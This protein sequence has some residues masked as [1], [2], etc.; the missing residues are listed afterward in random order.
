MAGSAGADRVSRERIIAAFLAR[1]GYG[2][3]RTEPLAQDASFRRYLRLSGGPRA[4]VVMDARPPEDIRPFVRIAGHL[5]GIGMSVPEI[6]A[7]DEM[8]GLLL[9][10]D[11]GDEQVS[12][13][14][15]AVDTL[16]AMQRAAPPAGLPAWDAA[17][18]AATALATLFDWWWPAMF[19]AGAPN[20]A[21]RDFAGALEAMLASVAGP[22]CFVHRDYFAG[23]LL[24]LPQRNGIRRIGVLDFQ[25]AANGHPAYDLAA[26]LQDA[27]RDIPPVVA[28][29]CMAQYLAARP[30]LDPTQFRAAYAACAVQR[31]LRLVGQWVR[32]ALRDRRPSYLAHGPR[33]WR[34][35]EHAVREP[36]AAP[37]AAAL[38]RW[39]PPDRRRNPP[40][41]AA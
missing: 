19:C 5:A 25:D 39:I 17:T 4:A 29:H 35:L 27:R 36:V 13:Y 41:I 14:S 28:E 16:I 34:L 18:M 11:F 40:A 38:D 30:E 24:W 33:T 3:A 21:R 23:N 6:Y 22:V 26:L 20:T 15:S 8:Q 31:H 10:E 12:D 37:L 9:E 2:A 1:N 7:V 32:L